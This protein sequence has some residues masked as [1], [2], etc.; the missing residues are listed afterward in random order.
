MGHPYAIPSRAKQCGRAPGGGLPVPIL[1]LG[2]STFGAQV[3]AALGLPSFASH[4]APALLDEA[5][6]MERFTPSE[7]LA[8]PYVMPGVNV[9][10]ADSDD[11]ARFLASSGREAFASR[12]L[13][14]HPAAAA[15]QGLDAWWR[16]WRTRGSAAGCR[17]SGT[18]KRW[19]PSTRGCSSLTTPAPTSS[20]SPR[21]S[22]TD[23]AARLRSYEIA[24]AVRR[25][26]RG[27][28]AARQRARPHQVGLRRIDGG[29]EVPRTADWNAVRA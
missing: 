25:L 3:A 11:E 12:G 20:S 4:F 9:V 27:S 2:S 10:A 1:I 8:R 24:A 13:A 6:H 23:Y 21:T 22:C 14:A 26:T 19:R 15:V 7:Q 5:T 18:A 16:T 28:S 17:L 29:V